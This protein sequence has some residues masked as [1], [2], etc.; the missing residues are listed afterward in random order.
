MMTLSRL[1]TVSASR[2]LCLAACAVLGLSPASA[3]T[4]G[5]TD[6]SGSG[7]IRKKLINR[8][9]GAPTVEEF[10]DNIKL[11]EASPFDGTAI[12]FYVKDDEGKPVAIF[13]AGVNRPWKFE[14]FQP[15]IDILKSIQSPVVRE[16]FIS[17][18]LAIP[19]TQFADAFDDE[20]WKNIVGHFRILA[21]VAKQAG[22]KGIMMDLEAYSSTVVK[23]SA[24][25]QKDK[26]FDEYAAKVRQ[27]GRELMTAMAEEY[28]DMTLFT[29][30]LNS[31]F[32]MGAWGGD[33]RS[34]LASPKGH[35]G[36]MPAFINGWLDAIPP[37]MTV[38]DGMEHSYPHSTEI[39][40]L[41][42]VNAARNTGIAFV[43]KENRAKFR[44]QVQA[45]LA[46]YMDAFLIHQ[47]D[48]HS[49]VYTDPP[50]E[51]P[52]VDRLRQATM[53][54]LDAVDEYVWVFDENYRFWPTSNS[55]VEPIY[56][57]E[58]IPGASAALKEAKDPERRQIAN[59]EREF[60]ISEH[61]SGIRDIP[62]RNLVQDPDIN[63][64]VKKK[65]EPPIA[66]AE[67]DPWKAQAADGTQE[68]VMSGQ[69][70]PG[71][72]LLKTTKEGAWVQTVPV[73][74]G[75]F[76]KIRTGV[77]QIGAGTAALR[78]VWLDESGK[79]LGVNEALPASSPNEAWARI[80]TTV[81]APANAVN[82]SVQLTAKNQK[83]DHD[84]IWYDN[85]EVYRIGVN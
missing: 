48:V 34:S 70:E 16:S 32:A 85:V 59:A 80:D 15:A 39:A 21:R 41:R 25:T 1:R 11:I 9:W 66:V 40:Y 45:G 12:R 19:A 71:S 56:W 4:Q 5:L 44:A 14:W 55:R 23:F 43:A 37:Q 26:T 38:V 7:P 33:P 60:A 51:G 78:I 72:L 52:L 46:I 42:R 10:R 17:V 62:L 30:F 84:R 64:V 28:P 29:L 65:G 27:R 8:G 20:G 76:Y 50:L 83:T 53:S 22:L 68:R 74:A 6:D 73:G 35:Y 75:Q 81:H 47:K 61:K 54:A 69:I 13:G 67:I 57:D 3:Q 58:F 2:L 79:E 82:L 18:S 77:R 24:G 36:L 31:G 63:S 49:D